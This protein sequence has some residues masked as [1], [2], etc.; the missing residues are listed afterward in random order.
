[1]AEL[2]QFIESR[3]PDPNHLI[4]LDDVDA[5][6]DY[7]TRQC[8]I[9]ETDK[10]RTKPRNPIRRGANTISLVNERLAEIGGVQTRPRS[11]TGA[12]NEN[13]R[14]R[15][16]VCRRRNHHH[17]PARGMRNSQFSKV[18]PAVNNAT[19]N[20]IVFECPKQWK[21][22]ADNDKWDSTC[23]LRALRKQDILN[24][25]QEL[26]KT[27]AREIMEQ[28]YPASDSE[29]FSEA[30]S[31]SENTA[32]ILPNEAPLNA[33]EETGET[34][35]QS[36][37]AP[38][39]ITRPRLDTKT[40]PGNMF[41][42]KS[43]RILTYGIPVML[44]EFTVEYDLR[45]DKRFVKIQLADRVYRLGL[46]FNTGAVD[47]YAFD[48]TKAITLRTN[49]QKRPRSTD[50]T[51]GNNLCNVAYLVIR[52]RMIES[53]I[54]YPA[55]QFSAQLQIALSRPSRLICESAPA[56][57]KNVIPSVVTQWESL[58][59]QAIDAVNCLPKSA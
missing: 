46:L 45:S 40:T 1:M 13:V 6:D 16:T 55:R 47:A 22:T 43:K 57:E 34:R 42:D 50:P 51:T 17:R 7:K 59:S 49:G 38:D 44:D 37:T 2:S 31:E 39:E 9:S 21:V 14:S 35:A 32:V 12:E 11:K 4:V 54:C 28:V 58:I 27:K 48:L 8:V 23:Q 41:L 20:E 15:T 29:Y 56:N 19:M 26:N 18:Q 33:H 30:Q 25:V 52:E 3:E 36:N 53:N 10:D 24:Y 5:F